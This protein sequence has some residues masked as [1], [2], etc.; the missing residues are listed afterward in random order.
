MYVTWEWVSAVLFIEKH[1]NSP[2]ISNKL[3]GYLERLLFEW[4][5]R[6]MTRY[7]EHRVSFVEL[8][9]S[10]IH[11]KETHSNGINS[12]FPLCLLVKN[13][14]NHKTQRVVCCPRLTNVYLQKKYHPIFCD[15]FLIL[16]E[17]VFF[18]FQFCFFSLA[19][20]ILCWWFNRYQSVT[21][22]A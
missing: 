16:L 11:S 9:F 1:R 22:T 20:C 3:R 7:S 10:N 21:D 18:F 5:C 14:F 13:T 6:Q 17:V 15:I 12:V 4:R 8:N 2:L 19:T